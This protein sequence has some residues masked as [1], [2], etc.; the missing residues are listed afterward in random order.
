MSCRAVMPRRLRKLLVYLLRHRAPEADGQ[1]E[2]GRVH[3]V[4]LHFPEVLGGAGLLH[5]VAPPIV[6]RA[7]GAGCGGLIRASDSSWRH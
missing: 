2:G 1:E 3:L 6:S 4:L 7:P 5:H